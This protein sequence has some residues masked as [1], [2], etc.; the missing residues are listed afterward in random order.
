MA[1]QLKAIQCPKCGSTQKV[2]IR[3]D[4]YR[5]D[6][7]GTEYFLDTDDITIHVRQVP[8]AAP[9]RP[10]P[11]P[12][13]RVH[14]AIILLG[15]ALAGGLL[16]YLPQRERP[17]VRRAAP[18]ADPI[19][20]GSFNQPEWRSTETALLPGTAGQPVLLRAGA[21]TSSD[22]EQAAYTASVAF[23][24]ALTGAWQHE[25]DLPGSPRTQP[26]TVELERL[27]NG[28]VL[29]C[30]NNAVYR[31]QV[32]PPGAEDLTT[33]LLASQRALASGVATLDRGTAGDDALH[34]FTNDGHNFSFYPLTRRLYT[35]DEAWDAA[36]G[37]QN[38]RPGSP[39]RTGFA[40]SEASMRYPEEPIQLLTYQY[41]F[42]DGGPQMKPT[43]SWDDDYGGSG[44]FTSADPHQKRL[45][46]R[47]ELL[48]G[49]V[50]SFRDFTPGRQY[51]YPALLYQDADYLLL[52]FHTTAA[53]NSPRIVQ[54]LDARTAAIRF[55]TPL[56][57]EAGQPKLALRYPGGFVIGRDQTTYTLSLGGK[58]GPAITCQ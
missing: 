4:T 35:E 54:A 31:V 43:F 55:S 39:V 58:L 38:L 1:K 18:A 28:T 5:C 19:M 49:R 8:A 11:V 6:N 25:L 29:V 16:L 32:A 13:T 42:N 24:D 20:T 45:I 51:F 34:V 14:W 2:E 17:A 9:P 48:K 10:A 41:R 23:Y 30:A 33:S 36:H 37:F 50:L 12:P 47:S 22:P 7:C 56:P 57:A 52:T 53:P 46:P 26:P 3:P 27:S 40:F 44:V 15:L 21:K